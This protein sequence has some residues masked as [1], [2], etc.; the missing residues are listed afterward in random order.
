MTY[1][2]VHRLLE[3]PHEGDEAG[4]GPILPMLR[5]ADALRALLY[6]RRLA[7]GSLDLDLPDVRLELDERGRVTAIEPAER[8]VAHR[9]IEELMIAANRAVAA[10]LDANE[11]PA[12]HRLHAPPGLDTMEEL[13]AAL[14]AIGLTFPASREALDPQAFQSV[15]AAAH[16]R[17]HEALVSNLVLRSM[18]R[19]VYSP[20]EGGHFAL[21]L[22]HYTHFTS[23]IRR[24]PDLLVHRQLKRHLAGE[25]PS[26][27]LA[28]RLPA[29][30]AECSR[31]ERRAESAERELAK[32]K[33]VR[34][35]E[36]RVGETFAATITGVQPFGFFAQLDEIL[37]DGL[38]AI[39]SLTDDYYHF[40]PDR[41]RL[42]GESDG[43][44]FRLGD[45]LDVVLVKADEATRNLDF[46]I[47][48]MP[49]PRRSGSAR[50]PGS[51]Y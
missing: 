21:S 7:A 11:K 43:R 6:E 8:N 36:D 34:F 48:D 1:T 4:Y 46:E 13:R 16:G 12:L 10:E 28:E 35:L 14:A 25:E 15:L 47:P 2:E 3:A 51:V 31:T 23:P 39:R 33:K 44:I 27:G 40:E 42:I 41:M 37:V 29:I 5:R 19:A 24:Y 26:P 49:P 20:V 9:L 38:V 17:P 18:Q 45:T 50:R 32:W 30:A 22:R